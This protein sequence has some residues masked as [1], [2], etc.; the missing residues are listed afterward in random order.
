MVMIGVQ[1]VPRGGEVIISQ[2][3]S[4]DGTELNVVATGP[5][6]RL[7]AAV[8][9]T[10]LGKAPEDGFDGRSIQPFYAGMMARELGGSVSASLNEETVTIKAVFP[11]A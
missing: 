1:A 6:A 8:E 5:R 9:R 2:A 7:D 11:A 4:T 3:E 10:L